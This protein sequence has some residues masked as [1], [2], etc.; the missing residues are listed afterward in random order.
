MG[1]PVGAT[2]KRKVSS[3]PLD[4]AKGYEVIWSQVAPLF[5]AARRFVDIGYVYFIGEEDDG[6]V[7]I[8]TAKD[9]IAR[10]RSLQ[11]GNPRRL[12]VEH[13]LV[14]DA[15]IER[16]L[17]EIW[18]SFA[19][20]SSRNAGKVDAPPGTE[21]FRPDIR[22]ILFPAV[23]TA[24]EQQI[25][26]LGEHGDVSSTEMEK[27]IRGAHGVHGLVAQRRDETTLL[28]QGLGTVVGSRPSRI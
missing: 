9:P 1:V 8:G 5:E 27:I 17:H 24:A 16:L 6:P 3:F 22:P 13:V 28:A 10:L 12:R 11:V 19:I 25:A 26:R 4:K 2:K 21:W 23:I 14:G 15:Y 20:V 7:K 18:E